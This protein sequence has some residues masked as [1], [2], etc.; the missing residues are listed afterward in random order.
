MRQFAPRLMEKRFSELT[1]D[2]GTSFVVVLFLDEVR[3]RIKHL[4]SH[5]LYINAVLR[6]GEKMSIGLLLVLSFAQVASCTVLVVPMLYGRMGTAIPSLALGSTALLELMLY[7]GF[8]DGEILMKVSILEVCLFMIAL[9][10]RDAKARS[11]AIGISLVTGTDL[12]I[13]A[14]IRQ[15]C[16]LVHAA[17]VC[18]VLA[19][20]VVIWALA[21]YRFW[22]ASG[23][24]F[25]MQRTSFTLCMTECGLLAFLAGQDRSPSYGVYSRSCRAAENVLRSVHARVHGWAPRTCDKWL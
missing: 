11:Q 10:R 8:S 18:P 1:V 23:T 25:E 4:R 13:E 9:L 19:T 7:H 22:E 12:A 2:I 5:S 17:L 15:K 16:T 14:Y 20:L 3:R 6:C 24:T 21:F